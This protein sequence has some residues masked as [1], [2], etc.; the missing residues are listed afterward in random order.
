MLPCDRSFEPFPYVHTNAKCTDHYGRHEV[1]HGTAD[2]NRLLF[3]AQ[4]MC[5]PL[6]RRHLVLLSRSPHKFHST[7]CICAPVAH[8]TQVEFCMKFHSNTFP[9]TIYGTTVHTHT[10]KRH[11]NALS[12]VLR[13]LALSI[14]ARYDQ[15]TRLNM[16]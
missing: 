10:H 3:I 14:C 8:Q 9:L 13:T 1:N 6:R 7:L 12:R 11:T 5:S 4:Q 16:Y 15:M 2:A